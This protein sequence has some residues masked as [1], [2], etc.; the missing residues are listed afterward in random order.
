MLWA[1]RAH[2]VGQCR[3]VVVEDFADDAPA[4]LDQVHAGEAACVAGQDVGE[5]VFVGG[6]VVAVQGGVRP[7]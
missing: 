6:D 1:V 2:L 3:A 4:L 5:D 7:R